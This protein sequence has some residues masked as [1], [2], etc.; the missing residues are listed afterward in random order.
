MKNKR[1]IYEH[2]SVKV[3]NNYLDFFSFRVYFQCNIFSWGDG[4][5]A[6]EKFDIR[7]ILD[8]ILAFKSETEH[9]KLLNVILSKMMEITRSD[10]GTLYILEDNKLHFR[11]IK[12]ITLNIFLST[13]D[14]I[15]LPPVE[16]DKENIEYASAYA[17][18]H[19]EIIIIDDVYESDRFNFSGAKR[20][21]KI[22]GYRSKS[23]LVLPLYSFWNKKPEL[24][25]VIQLLNATD[26]RT[27]TVVA[28]E[29]IFDPPIVPAFANIAANSLANL[30]HIKEIN[31]VFQSFVAAM[32]KAI[33]ERSVYNS[34]HTQN[35]TRL[36][37]EFAKHMSSR[38]PE[39][40]EYYFDEKRLED[41]VMAA[42]LHDIGKI[43]TPVSIMDKV[44]RLG[45]RLPLLR[46]RI[47]LKKHQLEIAYLKN[48]MSVEEYKDAQS[49]L[50]D[51]TNFAEK[52]VVSHR[53][54]DDDLARIRGLS[55]HVYIDQKG[56]AKRVFEDEDI[57]G[58]SILRGTLTPSERK[59]MEEH[60]S[61]TGRLLDG[62]AFTK[63]FEKVP[64][65][66]RSHHEFL[67]GTGYPKGLK[68]DE[69]PVEV[70][71][72]TI[73]DIFEALIAT[74]RPYKR[75]IPVE[76]ALDILRSMANE[77]KLHKELVSIFT[78]SEV[79]TSLN[80]KEVV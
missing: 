7:S 65:F 22:T 56:E 4:L 17:A 13:T 21:D 33:D 49:K 80:N 63:Y 28:Y 76:V 79:W 2:C 14:N 58:L 1:K 47:E 29:N 10:A 51:D 67:N 9:D 37:K 31:E 55:T 73:A 48:E 53:L 5:V 50:E 43:V 70:C 64:L 6:V 78:K 68:G 39:G 18:I 24:L 69:I 35:V 62:V 30:I 40:H 72:M 32:A 61:V 38:Y 74:D 66:A 36:C 54:S 26:P 60:V 25:G 27:D 34:N 23:M 41:L 42:T 46:N 59:I 15:N 8:V 45:Y 71:I 19:N 52:V 44:D 20:Y 77:G 16:L 57:E 75:G 11:I 3:I 12:N